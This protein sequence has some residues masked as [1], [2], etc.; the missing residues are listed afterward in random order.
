M[1]PSERR[2]DTLQALRAVAAIMVVLFHTQFIVGTRSNV[3]PFGDLFRAGDRGV[4]LFFVLSGFIIAYLY[5][6]QSSRPDTLFAYAYKRLWRIYPMVWIMT[7]AAVGTYLSGFGGIGKAAKLTLTSIATSAMLLP[8]S[9]TPLVNVTWTL[10]YEVFFYLLFGIVVLSRRAGI[11]VLISWQTVLLAATLLPFDIG[12]LNFYLNPICLDF[13]VGLLCAVAVRSRATRTKMDGSLALSLMLAIAVFAFG[14]VLKDR[15]AFSSIICAVG[16]GVMIFTL[17]RLEQ[18][19]RVRVPRH[20]RRL[21]DASY[22]IYMVHYSFITLAAALLARVGLALTGS[23]GIACAVGGIL[24]GCLIDRFI[25]Q[26]LQS[27]LRTKLKKGRPAEGSGAVAAKAL[28]VP[29]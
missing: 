27:W 3:I 22:A 17:V 12:V 10:K 18:L 4:D 23:I 2:I 19:G 7:A 20:V 21:G 29:S 14:M 5:A 9:D 25:D 1:E 11:V 24:C 16:A 6:E 15:S 8:Q 26:P 13:G 28:V